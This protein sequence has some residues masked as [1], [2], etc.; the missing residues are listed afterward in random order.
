[1]AGVGTAS[2]RSSRS[3]TLCIKLMVLLLLA[4][5][6]DARGPETFEA[7]LVVLNAPR[8][9]QH[10]V[11]NVSYHARKRSATGEIVLYSL[12]FGPNAFKPEPDLQTGDL[13]QLTVD[14]DL[15]GV[16]PDAAD[17]GAAFAGVPGTLYVIFWTK[18]SYGGAADPLNP[19]SNVY[20]TGFK[21]LLLSTA[22]WV[23][24]EVCGTRVEGALTVEDVSAVL[25]GPPPGAALR[26]PGPPDQHF[27][28]LGL[29]RL[30]Y[31]CSYGNIILKQSKT[32]VLSL[33]LPCS[34]ERPNGASWSSSPG[35]EGV[36]GACGNNEIWGWV[37]YAI[38]ST[39]QAWGIDTSQFRR[40]VLVLPPT[41]ASGGSLCPSWQQRGSYGCDEDHGC[42]MW[43]RGERDHLLQ[44]LVTQIGA[45][46][47]LQP[48]T[49]S[50]NPA[51]LNPLVTSGQPT[52][53]SC[54]LGS[55]A[56]TFQCF[57]GPNAFKLL[58]SDPS[59]R[60]DNRS[61]DFGVGMIKE[62][63]LSPAALTA[64][65]L[66]LVVPNWKTSSSAA[67]RPLYVQYRG[68]VG[69]DAGLSAAI[70]GRLVL[71]SVNTTM[72][73]VG[74]TAAP[75]TVFLAAVDVGQSYRFQPANV[76]LRF[77]QRTL[78]TAED[79]GGVTGGSATVALCRYHG[80]SETGGECVDGIDNDCDGL[81]DGDDPDCHAAGR[82]MNDA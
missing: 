75:P 6:S 20:Y 49:S 61:S 40:R 11:G 29:N 81:V 12:V 14:M 64:D 51:G 45:S 43:I 1:M 63:K 27:P 21:P 79:V 44:W 35:S 69:G 71:H 8:H 33:S 37:E 57:N 16:V 19:V 28:L 67:P 68:P 72:P 65:H 4:L 38:S 26:S 7:K 58:L 15:S 2:L 18:L 66:L 60:I 31:E 82:G 59:E 30:L 55:A 74:R 80:M 48:A 52:D 53:P 39:R 34:G 22:V 5:H 10:F 41:G 13:V 56:G 50:A 62:V 32:I 78:P 73:P 25:F 54:A 77:K 47:L 24:N 76:L 23:V 36:G 42:D 70:A 17:Q 9:G 3:C 46:M